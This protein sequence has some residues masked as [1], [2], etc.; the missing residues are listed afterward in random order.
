MVFEMVLY[1]QG[2]GMQNLAQSHAY[3]MVFVISYSVQMKAMQ[4]MD[5]IWTSCMSLYSIILD[6]DQLTPNQIA[7]NYNFRCIG[8]CI[9]QLRTLCGGP[10]KF[11]Q[12]LLQLLADV[13]PCSITVTRQLQLIIWF[14]VMM[15]GFSRI[16]EHMDKLDICTCIS[17]SSSQS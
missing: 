3:S 17:N 4:D 9:L 2:Q 6:P 1:I 16:T 14:V 7:L 8:I 11:Y 10:I 5:W 13:Y 12:R 15:H